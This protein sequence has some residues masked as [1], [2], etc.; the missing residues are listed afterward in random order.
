MIGIYLYTLRILSMHT[1]MFKIIMLI[2][3]V[4]LHVQCI[5]IF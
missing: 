4:H 3:I 1:Y 2:C 5:V